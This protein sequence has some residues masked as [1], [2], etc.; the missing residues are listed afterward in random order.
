LIQLVP[1]RFVSFAFTTCTLPVRCNPV[2]GTQF[3]TLALR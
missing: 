1:E 3:L 2:T